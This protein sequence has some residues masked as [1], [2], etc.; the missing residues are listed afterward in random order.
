MT[1]FDQ[2]SNRFDPNQ[3]PVDVNATPSQDD[4]DPNAAGAGAGSHCH[5]DLG[6][7][8]LIVELREERL[9]IDR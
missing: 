7:W 2:N 5:H 4:P 3:Q 1:D 9:G 6:P 8:H